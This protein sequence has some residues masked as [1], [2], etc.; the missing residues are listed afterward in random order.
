MELDGTL[1]IPRL[2]IIYTRT[3]EFGQNTDITIVKPSEFYK[4]KPRTSAN[5][6]ISLMSKIN[7][8]PHRYDYV[9]VHDDYVGT[10]VNR[11]TEDLSSQSK[12][13]YYD[14]LNTLMDTRENLSDNQ[15]IETY[16]DLILYSINNE[17]ENEILK[18]K[19]G[20]DDQPVSVREV[21][22]LLKFV[23]RSLTNN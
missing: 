14:E 19:L 17:M 5:Y 9:L 21:D 20:L 4:S 10:S 18:S 8:D 12:Q 16:N 3:D 6:R 11:T 13:L 7:G 1:L 22:G 23:N 2:K 15:E